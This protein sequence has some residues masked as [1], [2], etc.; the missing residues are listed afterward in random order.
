MVADFTEKEIAPVAA[1]LDEEERF[2]QDI[3]EKLDQLGLSNFTVPEEYGGP[4]I[5]TLSAVVAAAE[6]ARGCAG[7]AIALTGNAVALYPIACAGSEEMKEKYLNEICDEGKLVSL[8]LN[9]SEAGSNAAALASRY[10]LEG[11]SYLLNGEKTFISG[12]SYADYFVV[13]AANDSGESEKTS[14][15]LVAADS[16]GITVG[17]AEKKL[18]LRASDT[19]GVV[20]KDVRIPAGNLIGREGDGIDLAIKTSAL[21]RIFIGAICIGLSRAALEESIRFARERIQFGK[22]I[23]ANQAIQFMLADMVARVEAAELLVAR[24][25]RILDDGFPCSSE[26]AVA[27]LVATE[28]AMQS[29]VDAVQVLG[30][31]GYSREY[32]VEKFMRDAK[33]LQVYE[34]TGLIQRTA[35]AGILLGQTAP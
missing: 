22:P 7:V 31:Y 24:A 30:G 32:P 23:A 5:D 9:E 35:I 34:G 14:V 12:A 27:K 6:L 28:S 29:T 21:A 4:G 13:F 19:A 26:A 8:A 11:D 18:G 3:L 33:T 15:F 17:E 25:A 10:E 2:P 1:E 16:V 20:F